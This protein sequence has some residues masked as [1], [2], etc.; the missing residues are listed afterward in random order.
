MTYVCA[1]SKAFCAYMV[2]IGRD[3]T[4]YGAASDDSTSNQERGDGKT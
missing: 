1:V 2:I 4:G 3:G